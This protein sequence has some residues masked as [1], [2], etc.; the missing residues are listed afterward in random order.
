MDEF[1]SIKVLFFIHENVSIFIKK[2]HPFI[3]QK[4]TNGISW[5]GIHQWS[6][7][8]FN[9]KNSWS[10]QLRNASMLMWRVLVHDNKK[11][12]LQKNNV[13][14]NQHPFHALSIR[15]HNGFFQIFF[16]DIFQYIFISS[17]GRMFKDGPNWKN[18][19][20]YVA[21]FYFSQDLSRRKNILKNKF[22]W[23]LWNSYVCVCAKIELGFWSF[24]IRCL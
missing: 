7:D 21:P 2:I 23:K 6:W 24:K 14:C 16:F 5:I 8:N 10:W 20:F 22:I 15:K 12:F 4:F 9:A 18:T 17:Q 13:F 1:H 11:K 19:H 3:D